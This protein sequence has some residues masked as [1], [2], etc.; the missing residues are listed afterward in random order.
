MSTLSHDDLA[1]DLADSLRGDRRMTWCDVQL[2]PSGSVR[3][4]VYA[5]YKSFSNPCPMAYECKVSVSDFRADVTSGK[6]QSYLKYACGV[7]FACE[8]DLI[9]RADIPVHCGLTV[10]RD[11]RWRAA[12]KAV[13]SPVIIPGEAML[14]LLIDGVEREGPACRARRYAGDSVLLDRMRKKFGEVTAKTVHDRL[15]VEYEIEQARHT[16]KR[17]EEDARFRA[18]QIRTEAMDLIAPLRLELCEVLGLPADTDRYHLAAE[19]KRFRREAAEHPAHA[20]LKTLTTILK[21]SL[22]QH[23]FKETEPVEVEEF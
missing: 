13:L 8:G 7:Y 19:V 2:G 6:W 4:D 18:E 5:I 1:Q 23:G 16:A 12:K 22:D 20:K 11:G 14:K 15:A 17:I 3:P 9:K 21:R 10:L